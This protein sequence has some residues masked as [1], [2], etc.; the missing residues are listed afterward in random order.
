M[1]DENPVSKTPHPPPAGLTDMSPETQIK[2]SE[3]MEMVYDTLI[4]PRK[5][6]ALS[7]GSYDYK[8]GPKWTHPQLQAIDP[9]NELCRDDNEKDDQHNDNPNWWGFRE[10]LNHFINRNDPKNKDKEYK[11]GGTIAWSAFPKIMNWGVFV[12]KHKNTGKKQL[13]SKQVND[14]WLNPA[15]GDGN[16]VYWQADRFRVYQDEYL[17]WAVTRTLDEDNR[18]VKVTFTCEGPEYWQM[19]AKYQP[20]TVVQLYKDLVP[21]SEK[22]KITKEALWTR[23]DKAGN[24]FYDPENKW[25]SPKPENGCIAHLIHPNST[26][27]A[28]VTIVADG[29]VKRRKEY[30]TDKYTLCT[31]GGFGE[32]YRSSDPNIGWEAYNACELKGD[33][34]VTVT[35]GEPVGLYIQGWESGSFVVPEELSNLGFDIAECWHPLRVPEGKDHDKQVKKGPWVRVEFFIPEHYGFILEDLKVK[36]AE[37]DTYP[38][39]YG[40]QIAQYIKIGVGVSTTDADTSKKPAEDLHDWERFTKVLKDQEKIKNEY[41]VDESEFLHYMQYKAVARAAAGAQEGGVW[42]RWL[43]AYGE[44]EFARRADGGNTGKP[45]PIPPDEVRISTGTCNSTSARF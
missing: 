15:S 10:E 27:S 44:L 18:L 6:E 7:T 29:T 35:L 12:A 23:T 34:S 8:T 9:D 24:K 4:H 20:D 21:D 37:G 2:W 3:W 11:S 1:S 33:A 36:D 39:R 28:E 19:L 17:E 13:V 32:P 43:Q 5:Y 25:N 14:T 16:N 45:L 41:E 38:L 31:H 22:P 26:L 30:E 42:F 40:S